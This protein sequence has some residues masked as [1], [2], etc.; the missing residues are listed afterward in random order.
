MAGTR[1]LLVI[2]DPVT[3]DCIFIQIEPVI[4]GVIQKQAVCWFRNGNRPLC[5]EMRE[6]ILVALAVEAGELTQWLSPLGAELIG[7]EITV[8][9]RCRFKTQPLTQHGYLVERIPSLFRPATHVYPAR[10][11]V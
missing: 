10:I 6:R 2:A 7:L 4:V 9:D 5:E 1:R 8:D 3:R 11:S